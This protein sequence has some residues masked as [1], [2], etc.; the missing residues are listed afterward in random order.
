LDIHLNH[1]QGTVAPSGLEAA[2]GR[3]FGPPHL[4]RYAGCALLRDRCMV[5][6]AV[7]CGANELCAWDRA[8]SLCV[9]VRRDGRDRRATR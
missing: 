1:S 5:H 4:E 2:F 6:D 7:D 3:A 9:E 8:R